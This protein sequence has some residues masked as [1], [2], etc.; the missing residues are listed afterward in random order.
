[1]IKF[2]DDLDSIVPIWQEAFGDSEED[3][4]FF[5]NNCKNKLCAAYLK[6]NK[7]VSMLFLVDCT[8]DNI[9]YKYIY[10]ACTYKSE[11]GNGYMTNLLDFCKSN[12]SHICLI[13]A[14]DK[15][16]AFYND[17]GFNNKINIDNLNFSERD[18][19]KEYLFE[20]CALDNPFSLG[21]IGE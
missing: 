14:D 2:T 11:M 6:N 16:V 13:P 19:I 18:D 1:M 7:P 5:I 17:R 3:I 8:V 21:Y 10:A 20:G 12:F 15:L 9:A 4:Y